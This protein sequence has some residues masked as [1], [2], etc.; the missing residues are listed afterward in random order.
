MQL[1]TS[2]APAPKQ[3]DLAGAGLGLRRALLS[4]LAD[5]RPK[6]IS[7]LEVA[8]EN[9]INVG[10]GY[11]RKFCSLLETYPLVCH[12]LSLSIGSPAPL[13]ETYLQQLK[14]F[15]NQHQV[16]L[17]S[18][19]LS[20]C[21]DDGHLY[22]LMPIPFTEEAVHYV[23][24]RIHRVQD[25]LERKLIIENVSY[26]AAPA[27]EMDEIDFIN[28]VL[29]EAD[30]E[31]LLDV[32]N[33]YVNSINHHYDAEEFLYSLPTDRVNYFHI[34]G[35]Y[36]EAEDL[37]IDTHAAPVI[38][39]VWKLL[40]KAYAHFGPVPT[41]LERD[42]NIPPLAELLTEVDQIIALQDTRQKKQGTA[43]A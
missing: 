10:G 11:A 19:H 6:Q 27:Q 25:I 37:R 18:E 4:P 32:N 26:Y 15:L 24:S 31:L 23:A 3:D 21:S 42:F 17:Y 36:K 30:C 13:D 39:P 41:L 1:T 5:Q 12:G 38:D 16:K 7:F 33:I 34:A 2:K 20:Y 14:G 9:W 28:A 35:H 22:D 29:E 43:H 8:P 40:E